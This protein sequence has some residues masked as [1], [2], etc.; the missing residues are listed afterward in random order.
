MAAADRGRTAVRVSWLR[1][2]QASTTDCKSAASAPLFAAPSG[3]TP[4]CPAELDGCS[5]RA[6]GSLFKFGSIAAICGY[7]VLARALADT[8]RLLFWQLDLN[9]RVVFRFCSPPPPNYVCRLA[10]RAA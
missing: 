9:D 5:S 1:R 8:F 4:A 10:C 2:G 7:S 3:A 6:G